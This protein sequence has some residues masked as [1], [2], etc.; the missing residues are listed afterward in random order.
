MTRKS[1]D[2][3]LIAL[4]AVALSLLCVYGLGF[5][6]ILSGLFGV[7]NVAAAAD[8]A[9]VFFV[10]LF[11]VILWRIYPKLPNKIKPAAFLPPVLIFFVLLF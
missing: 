1:M 7:K 9:F 10:V 3:A 11:A 2:S 4:W 8:G 6:R 5:T